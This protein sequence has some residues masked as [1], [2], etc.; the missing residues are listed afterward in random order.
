MLSVVIFSA[1]FSAKSVALSTLSTVP[2]DPSAPAFNPAGAAW[3][4]RLDLIYTQEVSGRERCAAGIFPL[5]WFNAGGH[6]SWGDSSWTAGLSGGK[7][8]LSWLGLGLSTDF[9][10]DSVVAAGGAIA[11]FSHWSIGRI[12]V[13]SGVANI[14]AQPLTRL[15][16]S[17]TTPYSVPYLLVAQFT[18][19]WDRSRWDM[20]LGV[21]A[22]FSFTSF[23]D[24]SLR[25][26]YSDLQNQKALSWGA[27]LGFD[28]AS[29]DF[30][31]QG[32]DRFFLCGQ[33]F[34]R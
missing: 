11:G 24:I 14:G 6:I 28:F 26:G 8:V 16:F 9:S 22:S 21:D 2:Y 20:R 23:A 12:A 33:V 31:A 17:W 18:R 5:R 3:F 19:P 1:L 7:R 27:G 4:N 30:A 13:G 29:L 34:V 25:A 32:L 10:R 15:S